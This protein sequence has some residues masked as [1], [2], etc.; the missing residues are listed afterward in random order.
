MSLQNMPYLSSKYRFPLNKALLWMK[1]N[2]ILKLILSILTFH[3]NLLLLHIYF[4][5]N[6]VPY[7]VFLVYLFNNFYDCKGRCNLQNFSKKSFNCT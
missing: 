4:F 3:Y 6:I 5:Y 2:K 7:L 1:A